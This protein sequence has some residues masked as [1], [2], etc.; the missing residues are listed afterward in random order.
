M[1]AVTYI[2]S[3]LPDPALCLPAANALRDLCDANREALA[4][5][6]NAFGELHANMAGMPVSCLRV[7][8][9][10][11]YSRRCPRVGYREGQ[12]TPIHCERDSG[13]APS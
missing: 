5:H 3:A 11:A 10:Y 6:I 7:Q 9:P 12:G 8:V 1:N 2:A 4:P 13:I